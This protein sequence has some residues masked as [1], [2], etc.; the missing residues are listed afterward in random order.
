MFNRIFSILV[1]IIKAE[2]LMLLKWE[3]YALKSE[4]HSNYEYFPEMHFLGYY[5]KFKWNFN[6]IIG[7]KAKNLAESYY[8]QWVWL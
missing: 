4:N 1:G 2:Y 5:S 7:E 8:L 6:F 3:K